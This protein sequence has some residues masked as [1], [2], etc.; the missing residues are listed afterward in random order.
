MCGEICLSQRGLLVAFEELVAKRRDSCADAGTEQ[1][2]PQACDG[3]KVA[4]EHSEESGTEAA[5]GVNGG[6][7]QVDAYKVNRR[8]G[9]TDNRSR[10]FASW[11]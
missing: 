6:A 9:K 2:C 1:E 5:R 11:R 8:Q 4:A 10:A 3:S 7:G